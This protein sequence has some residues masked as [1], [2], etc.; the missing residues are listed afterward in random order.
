[1]IRHISD[2]SILVLEPE[3]RI[4]QTILEINIVLRNGELL[5]NL[6]KQ[7]KSSLNMFN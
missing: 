4:F 1:M 6:L 3:Q 2:V 5:Q 7:L